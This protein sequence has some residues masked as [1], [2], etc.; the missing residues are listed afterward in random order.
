MDGAWRRL[1]RHAQQNTFAFEAVFAYVFKWDILQAWLVCDP[2]EAKTRFG[3]L[4]DKVTHVEH[5]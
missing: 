3:D 2:H 4:I 1:D 5:N